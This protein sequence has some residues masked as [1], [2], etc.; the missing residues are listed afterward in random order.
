MQAGAGSAGAGA[1]QSLRRD[2]PGQTS[3]EGVP[4]SLRA[5]GGKRRESVRQCGAAMAGVKRWH[6]RKC[7]DLAQRRPQVRSA[8]TDG[9]MVIGSNNIA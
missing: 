6:D 4:S 7:C 3:S 9:R 1:R 5:R 2:T 8:G